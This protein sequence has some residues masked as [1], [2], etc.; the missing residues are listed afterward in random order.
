MG[1][2]RYY[3]AEE[4]RRGEYGPLLQRIADEVQGDVVVVGSEPPPES[5]S[6]SN[7]YG[8]DW[9]YQPRGV[10][11][12]VWRDKGSA[13]GCRLIRQTKGG[14]HDFLMEDMP[15][16][17]E[18]WGEAPR[19]ADVR[20][21]VL[22]T[23]PEPHWVAL[24]GP[25]IAEVPDRLWALRS[26]VGLVI[27]GTH[28]VSVLRGEIGCLSALKVLVLRDVPRLS[29]LP[30]ELGL[31][32][33]LQQLDLCGNRLTALPAEIGQLRKLKSLNLSDNELTALPDSMRQ[34]GKLRELFLHGND[35]LD[36]PPE[37]LGPHPNEVL[38]EG[39]APANPADILDYYFRTRE[40]ARPLNEA[41]LIL[42]GRGGVGKTTLIR[43]LTTGKFSSPKKT[44]GINIKEWQ[45]P[46]SRKEKVQLNVWDFGGQEIMHSTHQFF[47]TERSLYLLVLSGREGH[48]DEDAEYWLKLIQS[49]G[50]DSPVIV[51]LNKQ[52]EHP[53]DV[54][55][56]GL[57]QKYLNIRAF[58]ATDCKKGLGIGDLRKA[59]KRETG[60]LEG[61]RAKFPAGWFRIKENLGGMKENYL[62]FD[63]Y[64]EICDELGEEEPEAQ[65]ALAGHL[66]TLGIALNYCDD[67]RLSHMHVLN[68]HWVVAGIYRII[69]AP[70][71]AKSDGELHESDLKKILLPAKDYPREMHG[72]LVNLMKKFELCFSLPEDGRYL[73]PDLLPKE[74]AGAAKGFKEEECLHFRYDYGATP[75]PE[76]LLPRFIV[77]THALSRKLPRWRT[78]VVLE[79]EG[80]RA[81]VR[82]DRADK[83]VF[84]S[85]SGPTAGRTR[86]L[87]IIR[88]DFDGIHSDI[89]KLKPAQLVTVPGHPDV[90]VKYEDLLACENS[91]V[92]NVQVN[93]EGRMENLPVAKLLRSVDVERA[94][95]G[96][97][98]VF[99][100]YAHEDERFREDLEAHLKLLQRQ[101]LIE[102][103]HDRR[104]G[105]GKDWPEEIDKNL[106][107]AGIIL[108][109]ISSGFINSDYCWDRERVKALELRRKRKATVIPVVVRSVHWE[110]SDLAGLQAL[111]KNAKPID[112]WDKPDAA[113][114]SVAAK[115]GE[116]A[117][118]WLRAKKAGA[119]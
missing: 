74:Q 94:E 72:Y 70:A 36:I 111:P 102:M 38:R 4:V 106:E 21:L 56:G 34:L 71:L 17:L 35:A 53:F 90:T 108:L 98:P 112:E 73:V 104:I 58:V 79:F 10:T 22:C 57:L 64:R 95:G 2:V 40:G 44:E 3:G 46:L 113:W 66:H 87:A 91:G 60:G 51:V 9:D 76:G 11:L 24:V 77:R 55:R 28:H 33:N 88:S 100:S 78:G 105:P 97:V 18:A 27:D 80:N 6:A 117:R 110:P 59:I 16:G 81:L 19:S 103:W 20:C 50:G 37:I 63:K 99:I 25:S 86:L 118:K 115:I 13:E 92:P 62:T 67:A 109:L 43:R 93:L 29:A 69:N 96:A 47:L 42:V 7:Q 31:L 65:D 32:H 101:G 114:S 82:A 30:A 1:T 83:K 84:I 5:V 54:N 48:E 52:R 68:P 23:G 49:F 41:K 61:L 116:V 8:L 26:L 45:V 12:W 75:I 107:R 89:K 39:I 14:L 15:R 85:I 119:G